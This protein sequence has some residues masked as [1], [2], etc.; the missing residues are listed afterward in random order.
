MRLL[1]LLFGAV[2]V[3]PGGLDRRP[4]A[5]APARGADARRRRPRPGR[6]PSPNTLAIA[7]NDGLGLAA[8]VALLVVGLRILR[9]GPSRR[10]ARRARPARRG[11]QPGAVHGLH[12]D[13]LRCVAGGRRRLPARVR[14]SPRRPRRC[15]RRPR[16]LRP[17]FCLPFAAAAVA[18]GWW[19]LRNEREYG[20]LDRHQLHHPHAG[21]RRRTPATSSCC[22]R[23]VLAPA[24]R[25]H[26]G[27][28]RA[29]GSLAACPRWIPETATAIG[30]V[31]LLVAFGRW[32]AVGPA[33]AP[34]WW[35]GSR[36]R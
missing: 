7:Y 1:N 2:A 20:S 21:A 11:R 18:S 16:L 31:C 36:G 19:Y 22:T 35:T 28:L 10:S 23:L 8:S 17:L 15:G 3:L 24:P 27:R 29:A 32:W 5:A 25:R 4:A 13:R 34:A 9:E 33:G 26:L 30:I 14:R 6:R 12:G